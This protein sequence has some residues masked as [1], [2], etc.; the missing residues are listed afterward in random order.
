MSTNDDE[1]VEWTDT[2]SQLENIGWFAACLLIVPIPWAVWRWMVTRS[3]VY[4]LTSQ[5]LTTRRGVFTR[6][7]ED[8]ELYRVRDTRLEQ[9]FFERLFNVGKV[10]LYTTDASTPEVHL[11]F[12]RNAETVRETLRRLVEARRDAKR[13]RAFESDHA[14]PDEPDV[15]F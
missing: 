3:T 7:V 2:P 12:V 13:V 9:S 8:L 4:T 15:I 6:T 10:V 11:R 5:R 1:R 14:G